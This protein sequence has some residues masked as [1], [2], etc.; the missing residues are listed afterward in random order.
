[1]SPIAVCPVRIEVH[2][3]KT[4]AYSARP[5]TGLDSPRTE[6]ALPGLARLGHS[7]WLVESGGNCSCTHGQGQGQ[8]QTSSQADRQ[9]SIS[10]CRRQLSLAKPAN[11]SVGRSMRRPKH[12]CLRRSGQT[13]GGGRLCF[14]QPLPS[15]A[16]W[17]NFTPPAD[18]TVSSI[19]QVAGFVHHSLPASNALAMLTLSA[20][21]PL[22][23]QASHCQ[24]N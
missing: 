17:A 7:D 1:M 8:S 22:L 24:S 12:F 23:I 18:S 10:A 14:V 5:Q 6:P 3:D 21:Y 13:A 15:G 16:G 11:R 4:L 2:A 9:S 20:F 19:G